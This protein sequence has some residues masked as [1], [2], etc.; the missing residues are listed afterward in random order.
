MNPD[1]IAGLELALSLINFL[2][3]LIVLFRN[4]TRSRD[5]H[6]VG[7]RL[8]LL[9]KHTTEAPTHR[10]L[11]DL[12]TRITTVALDVAGIRERQI[13]SNDMV[14]SIQKHLMED[15]E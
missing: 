11:D 1:T 7:R 14:R 6:D 12:R 8:S 4:E 2:G 10:D 5:S 13:V 9:E 15:D 3:L